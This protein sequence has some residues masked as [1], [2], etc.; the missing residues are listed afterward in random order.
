M[1]KVFVYK[2]RNFITENIKS[3]VICKI[4]RTIVLVIFNKLELL[5]KRAELELAYDICRQTSVIF[6]TWR[7]IQ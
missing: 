4:L 2:I 7:S 1:K 3:S 5:Y 6:S